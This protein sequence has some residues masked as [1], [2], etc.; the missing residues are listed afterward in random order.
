MKIIFIVDETLFLLP[1]WL[2]QT[3]DKLRRRHEVI[4]V[5]PLVTKTKP[6]WE[7]YIL[8]NLFKLGTIFILKVIYIGLITKSREIL[9]TLRLSS[10]PAT[11]KQVAHKYKIKII[12]SENINNEVYTSQLKKLKPDVIV[13]SCSQIFKKELL[14]IPKIA[15]INRHSALLPSYG[16]VF[17]IF[18]ALINNEKRIGVTIHEMTEKI[19]VGRYVYQSIIPIKATDTLFTLYKKTYHKSVNATIRALEILAKNGSPVVVQGNNPSYYSFP[20]TEDW[21]KL[22]DLGKRII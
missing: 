14:H 5:T 8:R 2:D 18:R 19:D 7:N 20:K 6:T 21:K 10:L 13:S 3:I 4:A 11:I 1:L 15:C 9:F 12:N 17:P 16:G 22:F